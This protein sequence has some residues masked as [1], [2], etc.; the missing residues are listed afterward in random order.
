MTNNI[1]IIES[2][3][4]TCLF[5]SIGFPSDMIARLPLKSSIFTGL[6][7]LFKIGISNSSE[8]YSTN[9]VAS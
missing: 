6:S 1:Q 5:G 9:S 8:L 2:K 4:Q 7:F 3:Q